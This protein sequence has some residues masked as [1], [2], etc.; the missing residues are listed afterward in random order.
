M[1]TRA[2][3][4]LAADPPP[5]VGAIQHRTAHRLL[6]TY[7]AGLRFSGKNPTPLP[8]WLAGVQSMALN[9]S[10][11]DLVSLPALNFTNVV[12]STKRWNGVTRATR[13]T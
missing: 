13:L 10:H 7:P 5:G 6:R 4:R 3:V 12:H 1:S 11:N 9:F 2:I 8:M